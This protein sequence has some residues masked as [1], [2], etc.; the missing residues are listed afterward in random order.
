MQRARSDT[1][2]ATGRNDHRGQLFEPSACTV[3]GDLYRSPGL[4]PRRAAKGHGPGRSR[5][6]RRYECTCADHQSRRVCAAQISVPV[7]VRGCGLPLAETVGLAIEDLDPP[8]WLVATR[9]GLFLSND[10]GCSYT[11]VE[12]TGQAY[13]AL[14]QHQT[15]AAIAVTEDV[16]GKRSLLRA[17]QVGGRLEPIFLP[18]EAQLRRLVWHPSQARHILAVGRER[19]FFSEDRGATFVPRPLV[20]GGLD[21]AASL[22]FDI[23]WSPGDPRRIVVSIRNGE[24]TRLVLSTN[25][26]L[27]WQQVALLDTRETNLMFGRDGQRIVAIGEFGSRWLSKTSGLTWDEEAPTLPGLGC[28]QIHTDGRMYGCAHPADGAP[29]VI[30]VSDDEGL[31]WTP[32]L[33]AY[34][35]AK[36]RVDCP[37]ESGVSACC[38]A[39]CPGDQPEDA[40]SRPSREA[41]PPWCLPEAD[42]SPVSPLDGSLGDAGVADRGLP[43]V[44]DAAN[45]DDGAP[46]RRLDSEVPNDSAMRAL[47]ARNGAGCDLS[48]QSDSSLGWLMACGGV[49]FGLR[50]R[51]GERTSRLDSDKSTTAVEPIG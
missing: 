18:R 15:G 11:P 24:R 17:A 47:D 4:V 28:L 31:T 7:G 25:A 16:M 9:R 14:H 27:N 32:L 45:S 10:A 29:W 19:L 23:A 38:G 39:L 50:S 12:P 51:V 48:V 37:A 21:V 35:D 30:G 46:S 36:H 34:E 3:G 1:R 22:I 49:I 26:G 40:C 5:R 43:M 8:R 41:S 13:I 33:S 6:W 2:S 44:L 42:A 20:I